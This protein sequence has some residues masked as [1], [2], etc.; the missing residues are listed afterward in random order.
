M[1]RKLW[2][3]IIAVVLAMIWF[4]SF[5][6]ESVSAQE[7]GWFTEH[8]IQPIAEWLGIEKISTHVV[9]KLA[10][11]FE[12][13]VL[14]LLTMALWKGK[15]V[16]SLQMCFAAAFLDETFQLLSKRGSQVIDVWIDLGGTVVGIGLFLLVRLLFVR[17]K[18]KTIEKIYE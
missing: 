4:Q 13:M 9:R 5:L 1:R 2:I 18:E 11:A 12:Y 3:V 6:P 15:T 14:G 10:H 16:P 8:V 17:K 7:S